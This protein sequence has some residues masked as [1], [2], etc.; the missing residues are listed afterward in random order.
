M[1][2]FTVGTDGQVYR[3]KE[4][5]RKMEERDKGKEVLGLRDEDSKK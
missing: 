1:I 4:R 5:R 2:F 3:R